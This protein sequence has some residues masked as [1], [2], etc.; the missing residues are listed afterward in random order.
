MPVMLTRCVLKSWRLQLVVLRNNS[1]V[2]ARKE[3]LFVR[4]TLR[5]PTGLDN[6]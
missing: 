2:V 4:Y 5:E 3:G 6:C 1:I